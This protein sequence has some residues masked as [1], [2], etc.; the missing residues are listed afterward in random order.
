MTTSTTL[1]T[2]HALF[3]VRCSLMLPALSAFQLFNAIEVI[4]TAP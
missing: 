1:L 2:R 3:V 4:K